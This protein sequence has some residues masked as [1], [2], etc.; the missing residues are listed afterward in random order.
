[1]LSGA[2]LKEPMNCTNMVY[3]HYPDY[4]PDNVDAPYFKDLVSDVYQCMHTV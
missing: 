3:T 2:V 4:L 1:M